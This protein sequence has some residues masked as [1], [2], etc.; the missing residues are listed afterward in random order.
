MTPCAL[1]LVLLMDMSG[2]VMPDDWTRQV[3]GH[4]RAFEA[5]AVA[6]AI[7]REGAVAVRVT[8]FA[9]NT[10]TVLS[11]RVLETA[12]DA[13]RFAG[14]LRV[15]G[16]RLSPDGGTLTAHALRDAAEEMGRAP[17]APEREVIDLVT[18][19][20]ANDAPLMA[21][22]RER[23]IDAGIRLN[24]LFVETARGRI[25]TEAAGWADGLA[26]LRA[27]VTPGGA[28]LAAEG[29][30]DFERAIRAKIVWEVSAR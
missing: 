16:G 1:A 11:W 24:A 15:A 30:D 26:W 18:D 22:A 12:A 21:E 17:C 29:W 14:E 9:S 8:G 23:L 19:G 4:A 25:E 13:A 27:V 7:E 10:R 6:T 20:V 5:P 28:A 3:E 2:S